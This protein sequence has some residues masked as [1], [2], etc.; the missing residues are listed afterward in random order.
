[1]NV[2]GRMERAIE[3]AVEG[4]LRGG[5]D[6]THPV[7]IGRLLVRRMEDDKRISV[8]RTYVPNH[9]KV[10]LCARDMERI[11]P[12]AR[13]LSKELTDHIVS[14]ARRQGFSFV[15]RV[16]LEFVQDDSARPG[17]VTVEASF[18]EDEEAAPD[19]VWFTERARYRRVAEPGPGEAR[20]AAGDGEEADTVAGADAPARV[21]VEDVTRVA[22]ARP[23]ARLVVLGE[24]GAGRAYPLEGPSVV[25]GRARSCDIVVSDPGA[26]RRHAEIALD[27]G[28]FYITDLDSTNGTY[29]NGKRIARHPLAHG[30]LLA[31]GRTTARFEEV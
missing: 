14:R 12:L 6:A 27:E 4:L 11:G 1:M 9:Y 16:E 18:A 31:I 25:I 2:L 29:V 5:R 24:G 19:T 3:Q 22:S 28:K 20:A 7:E 26:S 30:D 17:A 8:S 23:G 21:G 15:G 13:T 10:G